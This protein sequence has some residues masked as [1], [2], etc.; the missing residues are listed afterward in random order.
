MAGLL[1]A[2]HRP[3]QGAQPADRTGR[4][5]RRRSSRCY[6]RQAPASPALR[7]MPFPPRHTAACL[8]LPLQKAYNE[9]AG[10]KDFSTTPWVDSAEAVEAAAVGPTPA[11]LASVAGLKPGMLRR[12]SYSG[13]MLGS[14]VGAASAAGCLL[15]SA[16]CC[17]D[18][19][20][21]CCPLYTQR[22][23]AAGPW[24]VLALTTAATCTAAKA[25]SC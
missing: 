18:L 19:T 8:S 11:P 13:Y 10:N 6:R 23:A 3:A 1:G 16:W 22:S 21:P 7:T 2:P 15:P 5:T 12:A 20:D 24:H 9:A 14:K 4:R 17:P 25:L